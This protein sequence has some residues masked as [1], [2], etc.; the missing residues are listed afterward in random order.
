M[1]ESRRESRSTVEAA[2]ELLYERLEP[3]LEMGLAR[4]HEP[5]PGDIFFDLE[6]D[7]FVGDGGIEYLF[8]YSFLDDDGQER[9]WAAGPYRERRSAPHSSSSSTS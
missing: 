5:S 3:L 7:P 8:G 2:G 6:G 4:L 1:F 9:T